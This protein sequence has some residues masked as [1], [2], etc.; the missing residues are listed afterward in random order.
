MNN[1]YLYNFKLLNKLLL[2]YITFYRNMHVFMYTVCIILHR[3]VKCIT[4]YY[5]T[6]KK[7]SLKIENYKKLKMY[8]WIYYFGSIY[9]TLRIFNHKIIFNESNNN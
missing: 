1:I 5:I 4:F 2:L 3:F 9:S 6:F 8:F 7:Y